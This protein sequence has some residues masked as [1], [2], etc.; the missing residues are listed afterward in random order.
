M[1]RRAR[2]TGFTL[3]EVLATLGVL[4]IGLSAVVA[5]VL[6]SAKATT[7]AAD[8]NI[9]TII[10]TEAVEDIQ[11]NH[12]ITKELVD[13]LVPHPAPPAPVPLDFYDDVGLFIETTDA[14]DGYPSIHLSPYALTEV[15]KLRL[16]KFL[17]PYKNPNTNQMETMIWPPSLTS[18]RYG[19]PLA[20]GT[21]SANGTGGVPFRVIYNLVRHPDWVAAGAVNDTPYRGVYLLTLTANRDLD[22]TML[23]NDPKKRYE[24]VSDPMT[25]FLKSTAKF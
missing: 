23:P 4:A 24:Q 20:S 8:R 17:N 9:A 21:Y 6:G 11:R 1:S 10:L 5:L 2:H 7:V 25:V 14:G 15:R 13:S 3:V 12:L 22:P 18:P 16:D 19:G